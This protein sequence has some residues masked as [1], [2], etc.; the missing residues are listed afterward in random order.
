MND[1]FTLPA[2]EA[3]STP[4]PGRRWR[5][6]GWFL[7]A[8]IVVAF[9]IVC[10]IGQLLSAPVDVTI[11]G[12]SLASGL[13]LTA[14][15]VTLAVVAAVVGLLALLLGIAATV[16]VAAGLVP[17]LLLAVGLPLLVGGVVLLALLSPFV[18]LG[19]LLW[20]AA[21]PSQPATINR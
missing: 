3:A 7:F 14:W 15:P 16:A 20:R 6:F 18:L 4:R 9:G 13:D 10:W 5:A 1:I 21:R 19:W 17:V 11:D 8:W 2:T 12:L